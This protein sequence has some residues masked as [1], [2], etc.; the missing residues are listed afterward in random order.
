MSRADSKC[1]LNRKPRRKYSIVNCDAPPVGDFDVEPKT[2]PDAPL[3]MAALIALAV[4]S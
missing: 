3:T 2:T 4:R 1:L